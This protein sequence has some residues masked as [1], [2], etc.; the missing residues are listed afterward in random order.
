MATTDLQT[1]LRMPAPLRDRLLAAAEANSR[2]IGAEICHRLEASF[3]PAP[4]TADAKTAGLLQVIARAAAIL[5][6]EWTLWH[7]DAKAF[8]VFKAAINDV[9]TR[10]QPPAAG[11]PAPMSYRGATLFGEG[12][13]ERA[14]SVLSILAEIA[15]GQV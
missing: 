11:K 4:V 12:P 5:Q 2:G 1:S 15:E 6:K 8:G 10:Q 9:L 3:G 14:G 13:P 7:A